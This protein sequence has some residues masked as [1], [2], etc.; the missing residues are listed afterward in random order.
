[1]SELYVILDVPQSSLAGFE[2]PKKLVESIL[3]AG[4]RML[5][6]RAKSLDP[7][8]FLRLAEQIVPLA[9]RHGARILINTSAEI[10]RK[11]GADG[12]HRPTD[13]PPVAELRRA[14]D[15]RSPE[16]I[17]VGVSTHSL[18]EALAAQAQGADFVTLSPIFET[19]SKP[20]YGPALGLGE[21][22]R[23]CEALDIPVYALAGIT[24]ERVGGCLEAGAFGVAAM[25]GIINAEAPSDAVRR[26]LLNF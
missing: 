6:L 17:L 11:T 15:S 23:V 12:V 25:G 3:K 2:G 4:A 26:Y 14:A 22:R 21:L 7:D 13:G 24:P 5:Q 8:A 19:A 9:H 18:D 1:M 10:C 20:G 16:D